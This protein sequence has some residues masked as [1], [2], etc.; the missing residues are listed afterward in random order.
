MFT[1]DVRFE[2]WTTTDW[3]RFLSLFRSQ[4]TNTRQE[5]PPPRGGL[6]VVYE[7][8]Q[9]KKLFHSEVGRLDPSLSVWPTALETLAA[10]HK[11]SWVFTTSV[12]A[13][14]QVADRF[15][16]R[17]RVDDDLV[18]QGI[19]LAQVLRDM[20]IEGS[21]DSW[22]VH[23]RN[24]PIPSHPVYQ[25]TLDGLCP[26]GCLLVAGV[27]EDGDLWTSM[28]LR[29][30]GIGFDYVLGP[31]EIR[32]AM[33]LLSGDWRRDY[34]HLVRAVQ[35]KLG[36][37]LAASFF[38]ETYTLRSLL[39]DDSPGA[40]ARAAAVR[41]IIVAP[42]A[43]P[44]AIPLGVDALRGVVALVR[45]VS[46]RLAPMSSFSTLLRPVEASDEADQQSQQNPLILLL[47]RLFLG[48]LQG[49]IDP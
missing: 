39:D 12:G 31:D 13:L 46:V 11:A 34:R 2:G 20:A 42:L 47:R 40:W 24:I 5:A 29:R 18:A 10:Q 25:R 49:T 45:D 1:R 4:P 36:G 15:G 28:A 14:E 41:D 22:P 30:R 7:G 16:A 37:D 8:N 44:V 23:L 38:A 9:I 17:A 48:Y 21:V 19:W 32:P 35:G 43:G 33:G 6:L 27:F 26:D 3:T